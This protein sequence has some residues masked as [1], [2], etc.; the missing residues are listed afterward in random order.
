VC[1]EQQWC[2]LIAWTPR[3]QRQPARSATC[4]KPPSKTTQGVN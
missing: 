4:T 1:V 3:Q 2:E